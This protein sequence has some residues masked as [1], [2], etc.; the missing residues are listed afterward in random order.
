MEP[1]EGWSD[2]ELVE[3]C[4]LGQA[5]AW[6][7][8][9][10][11]YA[12]LVYSVARRYRLNDDDAADVFQNTWSALWERLPDVRDRERLA[13]WLIRV[14][15][16]LSY[17]QIE[18]RQ[19]QRLHQQSDVDLELRPDNSTPLDDLAVANDEAA[20]VRQALTRLP[21]RCRRF[22]EFLFYDPAAPSYAEIARRLD[23]SPDTLGPLRGRC[24]KQ[25]R[26]LIEQDASH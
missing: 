13:P 12:N 23:V 2:V 18:Q 8:L 25:L 20:R 1:S 6:E 4:L 26:A 3:A 11:R 14:S 21:E 19:R 17:Q 5:R 15:G 9:V 10:R 22:L 24:L 16:R 7:L